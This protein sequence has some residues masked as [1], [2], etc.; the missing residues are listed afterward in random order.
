VIQ[1]SGHKEVIIPQSTL[2]SENSTFALCYAEL[3][4]TSTD[5]TWADSYL[6]LKVSMVRSVVST[7]VE[8]FTFG[9]VPS[10]S[11]VPLTFTGSLANDTWSALVSEESNGYQPCNQS[12]FGYGSSATQSAVVQANGNTWFFDT[13]GLD[14]SKTFALCYA[15][16][17]GSVNDPTWSD[18]GIRVTI[19]ELSTIVY[20]YPEK[21][22]SSAS[23]GVEAVLPHGEDIEFSYEGSL[24]GNKRIALVNYAL[25]GSNPCVYAAE[26][27]A[28]P[29]SEHSGVLTST[30]EKGLTFS[31]SSLD[32]SRT[33]TVC[34]THGS[35]DSSDMSWRDS[36]IHIVFRRIKTLWVSGQTIT[37]SATIAH[38]DKHE[39]QYVGTLDYENWISFVA[40]NAN[41]GSPCLSGGGTLDSEHSGP[42]QANTASKTVYPVSVVGLASS[43]NYAVCYSESG[44]DT[45]DAWADSG[46]RI[47]VVQWVDDNVNRF[48]AG[49][50]QQLYFSINAGSLV[51]DPVVL[52]QDQPDCTLAVD[53]QSSFDGTSVRLTVDS[54]SMI[55]LPTA[56]SL[57]VG[58]YILCICHAEEGTRSCSA[59]NDFT[60]M[61]GTAFSV[62][63]TPRLGDP[64]APGDIRAIQNVSH[65]FYIST[66]NTLGIAQN[67]LLFLASDCSTVPTANSANQTAPIL[68]SD[69]S[70][71][72]SAGVITIPSENPLELVDGQMQN[73]KAC[74]ATQESVNGNVTGNTYMELQDTVTIIPSPRLGLVG[75][76]RA[77]EQSTP[78]FTIDSADSRDFMYFGSE[79]TVVPPTVDEAGE[80]TTVL[81]SITHD[82]SSSDGKVLLPSLSVTNPGVTRTLKAC[83]LPAGTISEESNF[84]ELVDRLHVIPEPIGALI[85]SWV[86]TEV[87]ELSFAEPLNHAGSENDMVVLKQDDCIG[88]ENITSESLYIGSQYSR[89][90]PLQFGG[91]LGNFKLAEGSIKELLAGVYKV[92][93]ATYSSQGDS[94]AD[95]KELAVEI[96]ITSTSSDAPPTLTVPQSVMLGV[97]IVVGWNAS[98]EHQQRLTQKGA[99][100]GLYRAGECTGA[101]GEGRHECYLAYQSLP[102]GKESG[103]V[104]FTQEQYRTAGE[105]DVRFMR[106]DTTNSQGQVCKGLTKS[107]DGVYLYCM[108]E[109]AA[110][111]DTISVF[112]SVGSIEDMES[113]PGLE[114]VVGLEAVSV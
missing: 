40:E 17:S 61:A 114:S 84:V 75:D 65:T 94:A 45:A 8:H 58:T 7:N 87:T 42:Y 30:S 55:T 32:I 27:T 88:A 79:C 106:G 9:Q 14:P 103:E 34:Y 93:F 41:S 51:D 63:A 50:G 101:V 73:L 91:V 1:T 111:S 24:A 19:S 71:A 12:A 80:D 113:I 13:S 102:E 108:L 35:G 90:T 4:G 110:T 28:G 76:I 97:D 100:V 89:I 78:D 18:S 105:F 21:S 60:H 5:S 22:I 81:L 16:N 98:S 104:R 64:S 47:K 39:V 10:D 86:E 20:S 95:W 57:T 31:T 112:G 54:D 62:I 107:P 85:T 36:Y 11:S 49:I 6:R 59:S 77:I 29:D 109:A 69:F 48:V 67:D 46:M 26:I 83:F 33:F 2:L 53:A 92:C 68:V 23:V 70:F 37:T 74:F 15:Y 66:D 56:P 3:D 99:W 52:L 44:V 96:T 43:Q 82:G 72:L 38:Y 25:N